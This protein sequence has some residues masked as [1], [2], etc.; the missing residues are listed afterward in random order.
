MTEEELAAIYTL[1]QDTPRQGPADSAVL[2]RMLLALRLPTGPRVAELG[3]GS[4]TTALW[5][6]DRAG[7]DVIAMDSSAP[8]IET[9]SQRL[10][11][12][13]PLGGRV[14][15]EVGDMAKPK[16]PRGSLDLIVSEGAAYVIGFDTAME[17]WRPLVRHGGGM[18]VSECVW[19]GAQR[20]DEAVEFWNQWYPQMGT[21][22]DAIAKAEAA[23][24]QL[25]ACERL[26]SA[27]W[28]D[29]YYDPLAER[30]DRLDK[31]AE[32]DHELAKIIQD[33]RDEMAIMKRIG[34]ESGYCYFAFLAPG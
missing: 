30:M 24:W 5:L 22:S 20:S 6:A 4:G 33:M 2:E 9:L 1:F 19:W 16:I 25:V 10:K 21:P 23:G 8:F 13:A 28:W 26:S 15:P 31:Q 12:R 7:A 17:V 3:C 14:T 18:V 29:S 27:A 32:T 34:D 11:Q